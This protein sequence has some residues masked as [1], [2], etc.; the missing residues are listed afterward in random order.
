MFPSK[1]KRRKKYVIAG[2]AA[3]GIMARAGTA[4]AASLADATA[5]SV[6]VGP[7]SGVQGG[8]MP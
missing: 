6:S 1:P 5:G 8:A 3:E 4:V 2:A 7:T